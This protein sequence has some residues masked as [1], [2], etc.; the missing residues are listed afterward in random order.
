MFNRIDDSYFYALALAL[1]SGA[2][3]FT[4]ENVSFVVAVIGA[5]FTFV[6]F[7][8]KKINKVLS[9]YN[10]LQAT[11]QKIEKEVKLNGGSSLKDAVIE[12]KNILKR[13][14]ETQKIIEQRTKSSLHCHDYAL[15][16][17]NK[18]G[19]LTWA[20]EKFL[21]VTGCTT[22][23]VGGL[24]WLNIVMEKDRQEFIRELNSCLDMC[25][26]FDF[27]TLVN[28]KKAKFIGHPYKIDEDKHAG[29][30]LR[31]II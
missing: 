27:D 12:A 1:F 31:L 21:M 8:F 16:E 22:C 6:A 17:L 30:L 28:E 29:F 14:E 15:F 10:E 5:V 25:R 4:A 3:A 23:D 11:V 24:D 2:S 13:I 7:L 9:T 20:N 18:H 26:K 19:K